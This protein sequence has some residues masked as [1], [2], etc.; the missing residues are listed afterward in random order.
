VLVAGDA[1]RDEPTGSPP[2][3]SK[4]RSSSTGNGMTSVLFW[5]DATS[6]TVCRRR[7]CRAPGVSLM[8]DAA[9]DSFVEA[10]SSPSALITR[11]RRSRSASAWRDIDRRIPS[12]S[13]MSLISTRSMW[14]PQSSVGASMTSR[15]SALMRSRS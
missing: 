11:A 1:G 5:S 8:T 4:K 10:C 7:S 6:V 13:E 9:W 15:S 2:A 14:M 3:C 12:G